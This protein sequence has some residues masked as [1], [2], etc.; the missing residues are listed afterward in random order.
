MLNRTLQSHTRF[1]PK[2]HQGFTLIETLVAIFI[3][4][5]ALIALS[6]VAARG[7]A[8]VNRAKEFASA[9]FLAQ[10]GL[11][12]ARTVR[13]TGTLALIPLW[14][15]EFSVC[16]EDNPCGIDYS[17]HSPL[18]NCGATCD[19]WLDNGIFV[20]NNPSSSATETPF[21][22]TIWA[23]PVDTPGPNPPVEFAIHSKVTWT[24]GVSG[25]RS[26]ELV[27]TLNNWQ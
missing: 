25:S 11:E 5:T 6:G 27:T 4:S 20:F 10:E 21:A 1:A 12:A 7:V 19:L 14:H 18:V 17:A 22:R 23:V 16:T 9:Q 26:V 15:D 3:F 8:S 2:L 13:D 24:V